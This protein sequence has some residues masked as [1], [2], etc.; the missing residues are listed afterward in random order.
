MGVMSSRSLLKTTELIYRNF[1]VSFYSYSRSG[2]VDL[3]Y[4]GKFETSLVTSTFS[5]LDI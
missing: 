4:V 1:I 3:I 2:I 5:V